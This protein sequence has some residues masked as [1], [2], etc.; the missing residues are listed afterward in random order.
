MVKMIDPVWIHPTAEIDDDVEIGPFSHVGEGVRIGRGTVLMN[1]VT[2]H[3]PTVIGERNT[4]FPGAVIGA[5]PQ[6]LSYHGEDSRLIIG[7]DNVFR[8]CVTRNRGTAKGDGATRVGSRNLL[9]ACCHVAHDCILED[10]I[11]IANGVLLGGHVR[12]ESCATFGGVAAVHHFAT[13]GKMAF[14]GG[15]TRI[16]KDVPPFMTVEGNPSRVWCV[17]VVGCRRHGLTREAIDALKEAHKIIFR[18][19]GGWKDAFEEIESRNDLCEEVQY[20]IDFLR[21][22]EK[23]K[24]GRARE[25]LRN[26]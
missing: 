24:Q 2:I 18:R 14:V 11:I 6:D 19:E 17:N 10:E 25:R 1:N 13:I 5:L 7:D 20:L 22:V 16:V 12:V 26:W 4:F 21:E 15:L 9:M 3:G 23:G 8:E